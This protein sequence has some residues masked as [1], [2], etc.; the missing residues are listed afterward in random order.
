MVLIYLSLYGFQ[1]INDMPENTPD[2]SAGFEFLK[3]GRIEEGLDTWQ[4][5]VDAY[6]R[7]PP[8]LMERSR[9]RVALAQAC[10][11]NGR[12][13]QAIINLKA[14]LQRHPGDTEA[15]ELLHQAT[16]SHSGN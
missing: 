4:K 11:R 16:P 6:D 3:T 13:E 15:T 12:R 9:M 2:T 5:A 14:F 10:L 7:M 8:S 1:T